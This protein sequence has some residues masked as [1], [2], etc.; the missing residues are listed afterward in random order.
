MPYDGTMTR[1][2]EERVARETWNDDLNGL[3][4][5]NASP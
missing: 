1:G 4:S 3:I 5:D 2:S